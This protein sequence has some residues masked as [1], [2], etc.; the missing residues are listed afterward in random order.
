M[1]AVWNSNKGRYEVHTAG[2]PAKE[3]GDLLSFRAFYIREDGTYVY[4]RIITNYSPRRYC[5]NM[6][7]DSDTSDDALMIAILNYGAAAQKFFKYRMDDLM[8]S[9]LTDTQKNFAWDGSLVRTDWSISAEKEGSLVRNKSV[10]T[11]RGG[12]LTLLGAIDYVYYIK[13]ADS[14]EVANIEM[15][16]WTE[17]AYK[18]LDVLTVEN[19]SGKLTDPEW[20]TDKSRYEFTF[21]G[22][23]AK[24]MFEAIYTCAVIT[25]TDGN[26]YYGGVV[27]YCPERY[28]TINANS[29]DAATAELSRTL[30]IYGDAARTYFGK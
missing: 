7:N 18:S 27:P 9:D 24:E 8:N 10:V 11:S 20:M 12:Y 15:L 6:L 29:G 23:P 19:A 2:I 22:L 3:L 17:E 14:V 21:E 28:G 1:D 13:V 16:Y 26:V 4:G 30:V 25:D 5:Y